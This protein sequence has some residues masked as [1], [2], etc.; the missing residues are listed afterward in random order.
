MQGN[1]TASICLSG[2]DYLQATK[3][4]KPSRSLDFTNLAPYAM[5]SPPCSCFAT[6][7]WC[8]YRW[9]S[10]YLY[11]VRAPDLEQKTKSTG[12]AKLFGHAELFLLKQSPGLRKHLRI[13]VR[14]LVV[15]PHHEPDQDQIRRLV[16]Q[17]RPSVRLR[18]W[19]VL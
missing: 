19:A 16:I 10:L 8:L 18:H 6:C 14:I 1:L 2:F 9:N 3:S 11:F 13:E 15:Q 12:I 5:H 7:G 4:A 17:K